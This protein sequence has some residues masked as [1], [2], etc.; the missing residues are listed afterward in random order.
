MCVKSLH[1]YIIILMKCM[2]VYVHSHC[3]LIL[4]SN[5]VCVYT[6]IAHIIVYHELIFSNPRGNTTSGLHFRFPQLPIY[7]A[8]SSSWNALA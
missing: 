6:V 1:T 2:S 5:E 4:L 7:T 3:T 8:F